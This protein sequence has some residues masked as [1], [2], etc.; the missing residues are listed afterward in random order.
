M[1]PKSESTIGSRRPSR[2][3]VHLHGMDDM[4]IMPCT[5]HANIYV[6]ETTHTFIKMFVITTA[7]G[8]TKEELPKI[9]KVLSKGDNS[10]NISGEPMANISS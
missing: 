5:P 1:E 8:G 2:V 6:P 9:Y 7:K 10:D 3:C 4:G